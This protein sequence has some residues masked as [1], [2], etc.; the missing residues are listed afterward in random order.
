MTLNLPENHPVFQDFQRCNPSQRGKIIQAV[1]FLQNRI[2]GPALEGY[3]SPNV[4]AL[5]ILGVG[6]HE[7][8]PFLTRAEAHEWSSQ[9]EYEDPILWLLRQFSDRGTTEYI[10]VVRWLQG[11]VSDPERLVCAERC[12]LG[13][14]DQIGGSIFDRLDEILP[15]DLTASPRETLQRSITR[16][17]KEMWDGPDELCKRQPWMDQLDDDVRVL[18]RFSELFNEGNR[19]R[20]CI[21]DYAKNVCNGSSIVISIRGTSTAEYKHGKLNQIVGF[22]NSKPPEKD[23]SIA[24]K[25][26]RSIRHR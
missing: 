5:M 6:P 18:T 14:K 16:R 26:E 19:M 9:S 8:A 4:A 7:Q 3:P 20:H 22:A 15:E 24:K 23:L 25:I 1:N 2:V 11:I 17:A 13:F 12:D 10:E 21:A